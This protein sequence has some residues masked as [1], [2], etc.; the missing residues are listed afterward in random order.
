[1]TNP[2][3]LARELYL[4]RKMTMVPDPNDKWNYTD[5][6]RCDHCGT[7]MNVNDGLPRF[8]V[9]DR[10]QFRH[11]ADIAIATIQGNR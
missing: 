2:D 6:Y 9:V 1:M 8:G 7:T 11:L 5:E 4:H 10:I 3:Q